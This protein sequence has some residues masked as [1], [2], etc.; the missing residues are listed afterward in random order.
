M[1]TY[2]KILAF[3]GILIFPLTI[4]AQNNSKF[5]TYGN[6]RFAYVGNTDNPTGFGN[7]GN[8]ESDFFAI[9]LRY[10]LN[11]LIDSRSSFKA[12]LAGQFRDYTDELS[13]T[14]KADGGGID[15]GTISF[16]EFYYQYTDDI[17]TLKVGRFQHTVAVL[18]NAQRSGFRFQSNLVFIHWSDGLYYK[19]NF[20][21]DWFSELILEYQPKD[22][23]TYP[24]SGALNF[25]NSDHNITSYLGLENRTRDEN[26]FIQKGFG[27]FI[28]PNSYLDNGNY[29]TYAL[30]MGRAVMDIPRPGILNGGSLRIAG[31]LGQNFNN[32]LSDGTNAI[33]SV[34]VNRYSDKHDL[35]VEFS[36][37][38]SDWL[39]GTAYAAST[40][41]MEI[42]YKYHINNKMNIDARYRAR[43][44][45]FSNDLVFSSFVRLTYSL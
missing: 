29:T 36:R 4:A 24:Y 44:S 6:V 34:G 33:I 45:D 12:R 15:H 11:V 3:L 14:I 9:R 23:T 39:T 42:R 7:N 22:F 31:E 26:N 25:Q 16:D 38:D 8:S 41:E 35:M 18:S 37:T 19:R 5:Q 10:G 1:I 27:I 2:N 20:E 32:S 21:S 30:A 28:A 40:E 17:N 43:Q 13:F